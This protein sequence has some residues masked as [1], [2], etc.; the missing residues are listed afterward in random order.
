MKK[1]ICLWA[2]LLIVVSC[3]NDDNYNDCKE[4]RKP[5]LCQVTVF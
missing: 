5:P 1:T 3:T 4:T 2:L